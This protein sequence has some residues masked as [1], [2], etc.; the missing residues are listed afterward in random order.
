MKYIYSIIIS[1]LCT[2]SFAQNNIDSTTRVNDSIGSSI[3]KEVLLPT[4]YPLTQKLLWSE[5][6]LMRKI[7]YLE[8]NAEN[9]ERELDIRSKMITAHEYLGYATLAGMIAQGFVGAELYN[10]NDNL[11]DAHEVLAGAVNIGYYSTAAFA[12]FAPPRMKNRAKGISAAKIH[13]ALAIVHFASMLAT[14]ILAGET[15]HNPNTKALH[16][17]TAYTAFGSFFL[18]LVVIKL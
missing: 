6:G 12:L 11:K 14:N 4:H 1:L 17:A 16:R 15:E 9:R 3:E 13:K 8:L 7:E 10:G 2:L 18:S 5:K